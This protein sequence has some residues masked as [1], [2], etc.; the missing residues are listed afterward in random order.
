MCAKSRLLINIFIDCLVIFFC[1]INFSY[2]YLIVFLNK[3]LLLFKTTEISVKYSII[4][5]FFS[6]FA[7]C[8]VLFFLNLITLNLFLV[9]LICDFDKLPILC[10]FSEF[11]YFLLVFSTYFSVLTRSIFLMLFL[12][13]LL[14]FL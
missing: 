3:R 1:C 9:D 5:L 12:Y 4:S 8:L 6:G 13:I 11:T 14:S 10:I 7:T 2:I